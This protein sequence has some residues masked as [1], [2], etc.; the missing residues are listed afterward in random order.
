MYYPG[1]PKTFTLFVL[2]EAF[3]TYYFAPGFTTSVDSYQIDELTGERELIV[4][5]DFYWPEGAGEVHEG[6]RWLSALLTP[7]MVLFGD[8]SI[9]SFGWGP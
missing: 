1:T 2:L 3:G 8:I 4:L 9:W 5:G 6:V 7:E